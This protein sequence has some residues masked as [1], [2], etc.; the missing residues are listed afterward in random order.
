MREAIRTKVCEVIPEINDH[1][2]VICHRDWAAWGY[3]TMTH[4]DFEVV[5]G[6]PINALDILRALGGQYA[7]CS[8][9]NLIVIENGCGLE[10]D[11]HLDLSQTLDEWSDEVISKI[12]E[13]FYE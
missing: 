10:T 2:E 4:D 7:L 6:R 5:Y 11:I 3:G 1:E 13:L 12:Y 8:N 9:G